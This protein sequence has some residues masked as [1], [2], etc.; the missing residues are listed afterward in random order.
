MAMTRGA[1]AVQVLRQW[2]MQDVNSSNLN[3]KRS[4]ADMSGNSSVVS[5]SGDEKSS[6]DSN[7]ASI[8]EE[9]WQVHVRESLGKDKVGIFNRKFLNRARKLYFTTRLKCY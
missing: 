6:T 8:V 3:A 9:Q 7:L 5:N 1:L 2:R 4:L